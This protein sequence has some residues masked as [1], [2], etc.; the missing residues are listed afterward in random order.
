M[1][2]TALRPQTDL[3]TTTVRLVPERIVLDNFVNVL[4]QATFTQ[5]FIN[6]LVVSSLTAVWTTMICTLLAYS[7][8]RF[9][10]RGRAT[11][12]RVLLLAQMLPSVLLVIPLFVVFAQLHLINTY[13]G[14][15][16]AFATF[17]I[18][19]A[20]LMLRAYFSALPPELEEA[21]LTDGCT[22]LRALVSITLPLSLPGIVAVALF[23]FVLAWN[24]FLYALVLTRD[25]SAMTVAV[26]L[27]LYASSQFGTDWSLIIAGACLMTIPVVALF[28]VLQS[29]LIEGLT[30]GGVKG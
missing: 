29:F 28:V 19:F 13:A 6:S 17:A 2:D 21:A 8:S 18:P 23:G 9:Q 14:L 27:Y 24:D 22:R 25:T 20:A 30:V 16:L 5:T 3:F 10:Y 15:T 4:H 1:L 11:V 12:V 7:L 26:Q